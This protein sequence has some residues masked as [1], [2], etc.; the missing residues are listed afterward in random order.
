MMRTIAQCF[1]ASGLPPLADGLKLILKEPIS[2]SSANFSLFRMAPVATFMLSLV[3][4]AVVPFDYEILVGKH[5]SLPIA[6][7]WVS[8]RF[9]DRLLPNVN[10]RALRKRIKGFLFNGFGLF[11]FRWF[12][13]TD[14]TGS[15]P[16][17]ILM[18]LSDFLLWLGCMELD[19]RFSLG[20]TIVSEV[21]F[22]F[23]F[24]RASSHSSLAPTVEI[25]GIEIKEPLLFSELSKTIPTKQCF[26]G[27]V[28][29]RLKRKREL[30]EA[31]QVPS[32]PTS[33]S[34]IDD[35]SSPLSIRS[36]STRVVRILGEF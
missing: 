19:L 25:G 27:V 36:E 33:S 9:L 2:P 4:R 7:S 17:F 34:S 16:C 24:F 5:P 11:D 28:K 12:V 1:L 26:V 20:L 8:L 30:D 14:H 15:Y 21:M 3:A 35:S 18:E 23:A 6:F 29:I 31:C 22:L 10:V 13:T 32:L